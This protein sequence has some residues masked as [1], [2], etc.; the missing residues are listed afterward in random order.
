MS[1]DDRNE[2]GVKVLHRMLAYMRDEAVRLRVSEVA[3]LLEQ[4]ENAVVAFAPLL[5]ADQ[6]E[7]RL[8]REA[9]TQEH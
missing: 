2:Q 5:L 6:V 1:D 8:G 9:S 7:G 4:A 3:F